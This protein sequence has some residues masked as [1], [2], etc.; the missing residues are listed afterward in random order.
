MTWKASSCSPTFVNVRFVHM[1]L[2]VN[3]QLG[4]GFYIITISPGPGPWGAIH[5]PDLMKGW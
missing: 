1:A 5:T 2:F 4:L 3:V